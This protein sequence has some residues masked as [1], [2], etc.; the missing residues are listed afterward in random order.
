[1]C[2]AC[3]GQKTALASL[4]LGLLVV[5]RQL[6]GAVSAENLTCI[7]CK[8]SHSSYPPSHRSSFSLCF[9]NGPFMPHTSYLHWTV[10]TLKSHHPFRWS[11]PVKWVN[12]TPHGNPEQPACCSPVHSQPSGPLTPNPS[13]F[14]CSPQV[15]WKFR[16][17]MIFWQSQTLLQTSHGYKMADCGT[18]KESGISHSSSKDAVTSP[19]PSIRSSMAF[20]TPLSKARASAGLWKVRPN[21]LLSTF[22]WWN[23]GLALV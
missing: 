12:P 18:G 11:A 17:L 2:S 6:L 16:H 19:V 7:L 21:F 8:S 9:A 10:N 1:M 22:Q 14:P 13:P 20:L 4:E 5:I 3:R 15:C 23:V